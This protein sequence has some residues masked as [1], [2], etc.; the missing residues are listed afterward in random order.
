M[1]EALQWFACE[2]RQH[3]EN[4]YH[5]LPTGRTETIHVPK[6]GGGG[7]GLGCIVLPTTVAPPER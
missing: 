6:G 4:D 1:S 3:K 2:Q 5:L 7:G